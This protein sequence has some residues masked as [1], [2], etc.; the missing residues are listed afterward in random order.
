LLE[1]ELVRQIEEHPQDR[2]YTEAKEEKSFKTDGIGII[3]NVTWRSRQE[4]VSTTLGKWII[5]T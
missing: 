1:P 3:L 4:E 2:R 5:T